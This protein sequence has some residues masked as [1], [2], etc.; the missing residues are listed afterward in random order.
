MFRFK[1]LHLQNFQ[2]LRKR[3]TIEFAPLTFIFGSNS[4]G[5][6]AVA[7]ALRFFGDLAAGTATLRQL[8]Q[9]R[10]SGDDVEGATVVGVGLEFNQDVN[11]SLLLN[12][13]GL[14]EFSQPEEPV[15]YDRYPELWFLHGMFSR[16]DLSFK[17]VKKKT[18]PRLGELDVIFH[19]MPEANMFE[20]NLTHLEVHLDGLPLV[21]VTGECG[22]RV[23]IN[24]KHPSLPNP[25]H[26]SDLRAEI[27]TRA[28]IILSSL[29]E[30]VRHYFI[31]VTEEEI[32]L[33]CL[34]R[35]FNGLT[36]SPSFSK[37]MGTIDVN[38]LVAVFEE[39]VSD[40][41]WDTAELGYSPTVAYKYLGKHFSCHEDVDDIRRLL[42]G[43][44]VYPARICGAVAANAVRVG[45]IRSIPT[46]DQLAWV[47]ADPLRDTE[48]GNVDEYHAG[49]PFSNRLVRAAGN[50][51]DGRQAWETL[52][53]SE[54][55][56]VRV[57]DW[58]RQIGI[59]SNVIARRYKLESNPEA[60]HSLFSSANESLRFLR[61][62]ES[63]VPPPAGFP[64]ADSSI[65]CLFLVDQKQKLSV[66]VSD[67][68]AGIPQVIPVLA[69]LLEASVIRFLEQPELHLHPRMQLAL[70]DILADDHSCIEKSYPNTKYQEVETNIIETHSEHIALRILK[71]IRLG[72]KPQR[73]KVIS[74]NNVLFL[75]FKTRQDGTLA[76]KIRV[77]SRGRFVDKW[78]DG[79][80]AERIDEIL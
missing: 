13:L 64:S 5:K 6:S 45:P 74:A 42:A 57:N 69:S 61:E 54:D 43:I 58:L 21:T 73:K 44:V 55:K 53:F 70:A 35:P 10:T 76:H 25:R 72:K 27:E 41:E 65:T 20:S 63:S 52:A 16:D 32:S 33:K 75:Y 23:V 14:D 66:G 15:D 12:W 47:R 3:Q 39:D 48:K 31:E 22:H 78:P 71:K 62:L 37:P 80:F 17:K 49:G 7:D 60:Q 34:F 29:P 59:T 9:W 28:E 67:V 18:K 77:D 1:R 56:R 46:P 68:G 26:L 30:K 36:L 51:E 11:A 79:F 40:E 50:W 2:S 8:R 24:R 38:N 19:V 4:A